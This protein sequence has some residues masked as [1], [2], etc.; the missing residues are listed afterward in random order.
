MTRPLPFLLLAL[1][2]SAAA[3][4]FPSTPPEPGPPRAFEIPEGRS[5]TLDNGVGVTLVPYGSLPKADVRAVVRAG[6]V[7][8]A[9]DQT[10]LADL[11]AALLTE[12]TASRTSEQIATEAAEMGG[13]I[14]A[15]AGLDQTFV[16]GR[17]LG[18]FTPDLV[19]LMA[20]V[21]RNP[22]FPADAFERVQ[23]DALRGAAVARSRPG[24]VAQAAFYRTL[25]GDHPYA[26]VILPDAEDIEAASA[27]SVR[28]FY[29]AQVGP[30]RTHLYV[31]G[32]FDE[33]AVERAVRDAFGGWSGGP[34][35]SDPAPPTATAS[36]RV[37]LV[38]QPGAA[39]SNVVVG[40]P[41]IDP[42]DPDY[43]ALQVTNALLGGS[44]GSRITR[45]I[46]EDK[47][48]T[49]SPSSS[50][51]ARF[52]NAYWA[53]SAAIQT[54]ATGPAISEILSEIDS[55]A[56]TAPPAEELEG[57]QNYLAG[58]F[59]LQNS[60]AGGIASFLAF[61]DLHGLGRDYLEGYVGRVYAV[62]PEDVRRTVAERLRAGDLAIVRGGR[63]ERGRG[64]PGRVR[65]RLRRDGRVAPRRRPPPAPDGQRRAK[66]A[67]DW[68][69][70]RAASGTVRNARVVRLDQGGGA[71]RGVPSA[72]S[73][74][75]RRS[76]PRAPPPRSRSLRTP[77][78]P[79][80]SPSP[81]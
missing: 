73:S 43:V 40:L 65:G 70:R 59:T 74:P 19:R 35:P 77:C 66:R 54:P 3:Q 44:F 68:R 1:A 52:R 78:E 21:L 62:T 63:P 36:R 60:S 23:R 41:T 6:N 11:V 24:A 79:P 58:T 37:V 7:D 51:S 20:D 15:G 67:P 33:R 42:S 47:G 10:S 4:D 71:G 81:C 13:S 38:D 32:R 25:Y 9:D 22:A 8:E 61:L 2:A 17:V 64:R 5:F 69:R 75:R 76:R 39:Q 55:L 49:Y 56:T 27:E 46:R 72:R 14:S 31:V 53:E 45:N 26:Q 28:A 50:V 34:E 48:Y 80:S 30:R 12:G 16:T 18:E 57:V 29:D